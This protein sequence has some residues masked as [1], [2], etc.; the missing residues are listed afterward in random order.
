[1]DKDKTTSA[2]FFIIALFAVG[3]FLSATRSSAIFV[4]ISIIAFIFFSRKKI[5]SRKKISIIIVV[6]I[7]GFIATPFLSILLHIIIT[8]FSK[9]ISNINKKTSFV[10]TINRNAVWPDAWRITFQTL[11]I[12]GHGPMQGMV[13]GMAK[14]N[15]NKGSK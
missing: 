1:M 8:R 13:L 5:Y 14:R 12:F 11:S 6:L 7:V 10:K 9:T 4:L 2:H 15:Y 3:I